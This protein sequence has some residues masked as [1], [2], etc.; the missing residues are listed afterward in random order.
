LEALGAFDARFMRVDKDF[1]K[2]KE[3][4]HMNKDLAETK[5]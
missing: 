4:I 3:L 2:M 1:S 5:I